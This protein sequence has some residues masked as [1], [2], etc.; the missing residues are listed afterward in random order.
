MLGTLA[1]WLLILGFDT[2]Y[3]AQVD[4]AELV[5]RALEEGRVL[6]TRDR[7]LVE[8]R[9]LRDNAESHLLI[10]EDGIERQ[11]RQ[12]IDELRLEIRTTRLFGRCLH[13]NARLAGLPAAEARPRVPPFVARTQSRFRICPSC[14]RIYWRATHVEAM[15]SRLRSMEIK[16]V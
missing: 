16:A 7:R 3:D 4:D 2:A 11:L 10:R 8:R 1:R 15:V 9:V 5:A 14:E 6:L 12:V 13:C